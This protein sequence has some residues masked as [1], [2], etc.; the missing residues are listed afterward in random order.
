MPVVTGFSTWRGREGVS[1]RG[2]SSCRQPSRALPGSVMLLRRSSCDRRTCGLLVNWLLHPS[3]KAYSRGTQRGGCL[4]LP[5]RRG[6]PARWAPAPAAGR[7]EGGTR[8]RDRGAD[9]LRL[10]GG[11]L[12]VHA[13]AGGPG[14]GGANA[15]APSS[16]AIGLPTSV[17]RPPVRC[18][19]LSPGAHQADAIPLCGVRV[20]HSRQLQPGRQQINVPHLRQQSTGRHMQRGMCSGGDGQQRGWAG[21][22]SGAEVRSLQRLASECPAARP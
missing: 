14:V 12:H 22:A 7:G 19:R 9:A 5:T 20:R 18:S 15:A 13:P 6:L 17:S 8:R 11:S 2:S 1:E 16:Q 21:S 10:A 4:G 3:A